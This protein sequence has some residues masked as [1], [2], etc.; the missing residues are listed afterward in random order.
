MDRITAS[1]IHKA[2]GLEWDRVFLLKDTCKQGKSLEED[3]IAYVGI[4]R[5]RTTLFLVGKGAVANDKVIAEG[6][7]EVREV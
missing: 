5:P 3:N 4:T 2:K 6:E 7:K 1:S